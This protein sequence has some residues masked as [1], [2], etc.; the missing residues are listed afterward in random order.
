[1]VATS[2]TIPDLLSNPKHP[3]YDKSF[4][5]QCQFFSAPEEHEFN[6][7]QLLGLTD[8]YTQDDLKKASRALSMYLHPDKNND[9]ADAKEGFQ[10]FECAKNYLSF[11]FITDPNDRLEALTELEN[12][13]F[14]QKKISQNHAW[15]FSFFNVFNVFNAFR[16]YFNPA[17][18]A[19]KTEAPFPHENKTSTENQVYHPNAAPTAPQILTFDEFMH[20]LQSTE[21]R[22]KLEQLKK[23]SHLFDLNTLSGTQLKTLLTH[24]DNTSQTFVIQKLANKLSVIIDSHK[25]LNDVLNCLNQQNKATLINTPG[26]H[27]DQIFKNTHNLIDVIN[28]LD[29]QTT[30]F[31][32][33]KLTTLNAIVQSSSELE[34]L[35]LHLNSES[36]AYVL[37]QLQ[38]NLASLLLINTVGQLIAHIKKSDAYSFGNAHLLLINAVK[39]DLKEIIKSSDELAGLVIKLIPTAITLTIKILGD[40]IKTIMQHPHALSLITA[41]LK[42]A[43][44][45]AVYTAI[46]EIIKSS[47]NVFS[48]SQHAIPPETLNNTNWI[49]CVLDLIENKPSDVFDSAQ[50]LGRALSFLKEEAL[51]TVINNLH[52]LI[53]DNDYL[54]ELLTHLDRAQAVL[55]I[56]TLKKQTSC[57]IDD[58]GLIQ[59]AFTM[60]DPSTIKKVIKTLV[61]NIE[62]FH[63]LANSLTPSQIQLT[64]EAVEATL[65]PVIRSKEDIERLINPLTQAQRE[66][67]FSSNDFMLLA[68]TYDR[69][70]FLY[71]SETLKSSWSMQAASYLPFL[72]LALQN[73]EICQSVFLGLT[74]GLIVSASLFTAGISLM[75]VIAAG[76][77]TATLSGASFFALTEKSPSQTNDDDPMPSPAA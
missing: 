9:S 34:A 29:A 1:M 3:L 26:I 42:P 44:K 22:Q 35:L 21:P 62:S 66:A 60:N 10:G 59:A 23:H 48:S 73:P 74:F 39:H 55:T 65:T 53:V 46:K 50:R 69:N 45:H 77:I 57:M 51:T 61:N 18:K 28:K 19:P 54:I 37:V 40:D 70:Y 25:T 16:N 6:A 30:T 76:A 14:Y 43:Q 15:G 32:I 58:K 38:P 20:T 56:N 4:Q 72:A 68:M 36:Y 49:K 75:P 11:K 47:D 64:F 8:N 52:G 27:F 2:K 13:P 31:L 33:K 24:I 7:E 41:S 5:E 12:N 63:G 67:L 17:N 71:A